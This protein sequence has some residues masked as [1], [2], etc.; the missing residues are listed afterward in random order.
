MR[1]AGIIATVALALA[2]AGCGSSRP[3]TVPA[4]LSAGSAEALVREA[5]ACGALP[6][7]L[8]AAETQLFD[9][10]EARMG[11]FLTAALA[12]GKL[13]DSDRGTAEWMLH[14]VIEVNAPGK[15]A[16]EFR[17]ATAEKSENS[18]LGYLPGKP[19]AMILYDP[20][21]SHCTEVIEEL[22]GLGSLVDVLAVCVEST[23]KRW[24]QTR[25]SLPADWVAAYDRSDVMA[26]DIYVIRRLPSV[27][28]LDADRKVILK[29]PAP[30]DLLN[31]LKG[32]A[33]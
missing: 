11:E 20:D 4:D 9:T 28:L 14:D 6:K 21:C 29:N 25:G 33:K 23:P 27:Y 16:A 12:S 2:A 24:E 5:A 8:E 32:G 19:L 7:L 26:N 10:D 13:S 22:S 18:L 3:W 30:G 17:F 1:H 15:I 31:R